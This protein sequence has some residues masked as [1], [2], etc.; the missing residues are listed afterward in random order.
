VKKRV[1][2]LFISLLLCI[3]LLPFSALA[4]VQPLSG[5]PNTVTAVFN[6]D[7]GH[8]VVSG[9]NMDHDLN[10]AISLFHNGMSQYTFLEGV[11]ANGIFQT[12]STIQFVSPFPQL[13][14]LPTIYQL[15]VDVV[16]P[17]Q[18]STWTG[19][20]FPWSFRG[21]EL[22]SSSSL[23]TLGMPF[24]IQPTVIDSCDNVILTTAVW[25]VVAGTLPAGVTFD[26][27]TGVVSGTPT[28]L[29]DFSI[30]VRYG[31]A[32][33][34]T[35]ATVDIRV[36]LTLQPP[37]PPIQPPSQ[38]PTQ[39]PP[40]G[41][42]PPPTTG[43]PLLPLIG[44]DPAQP[45]YEYEDDEDYYD[46]EDDEMPEQRRRVIRFVMDEY[47]YTIDSVPHTNDVTPFL[48]RSYDRVMIP[49]RAVSEALGAEV[50]WI[51]D[52]LT[53]LIF[54]GDETQTL[55]VGVSLPYGMGIP[56]MISDRVLVPLRFVAE[57]LGAEV[58]WDGENMAA[59][60]YM[61]D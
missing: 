1:L 61:F 55:V 45:E 27:N 28:E 33:L 41:V 8:L 39:Q 44:R 50:E 16:N 24:I 30:T 34:Y 5:G 48:D 26:G 49:L 23:V 19:A 43:R 2:K 53:V 47:V 58:R 59:Y 14:Q 11:T 52:V 9:V 4:G 36:L 7:T 46:E 15:R 32:I 18:S 6:A 17:P 25:S 3:A 38:P 29:G 35:I 20:Y 37:Q 51:G 21:P 10:H 13:Q 56:V 57:R 54:I 40:T 60:V 12:T 31:N 22:H 42:T